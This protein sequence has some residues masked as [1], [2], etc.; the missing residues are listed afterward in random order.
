M[1]DD[2]SRR[3]GWTGMGKWW[4]ASA[5]FAAV[6]VLGLIAIFVLPNRDATGGTPPPTKTTPAE[7]P[8][9]VPTSPMSPSSNP[10]PSAQASG[11]SDLGCNSHPG[12]DKMPTTAPKTGWDPVGGSNVPRSDTYG[13]TKINGA[14]RQCY[15]HSPTG[16]VFAVAT[17]PMVIGADPTQAAKVIRA[18]VA[19]SKSR[20][21]MINEVR[22]NPSSYVQSI[23]GFRVQACNPKRC[24]IDIVVT[25]DGGHLGETT[26]SVVWMHGDWLMDASSVTGAQAVDQMPAGFVSWGG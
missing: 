24:N 11:W 23:A 19:P 18:G 25:Y 15:Q 26:A 7:P 8:S 14:V 10:S 12:S 5:I 4:I 22:A 9:S 20:D 1:S 16:A 6:I 17:I 13:P 21:Q 3:E 2:D